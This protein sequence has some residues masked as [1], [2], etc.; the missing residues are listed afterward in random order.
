MS[1]FFHKFPKI[2]ATETRNATFLNNPEIPDGK[3]G[4]LELYCTKKDC[5]CRRLLINVIDV[6]NNCKQVATISY[7]FDDLKYYGSTKSTALEN[8]GPFLDP[9]NIQSK[10]SNF[11]L[12][13]FKNTILKDEKY[14]QRL[15]KHYK[16]F[17]KSVNED[18]DNKRKKPTQYEIKV[19]RNSPCPCGSGKKFKKCCLT[20]N[21]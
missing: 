1:Y 16:M 21:S 19:P 18:I 14:I 17:K 7:G 6:N 2:A 8:K 5:D 3:Y 4:F 11:L 13:F 20:K 12:K 9:L 10:Y 15:K